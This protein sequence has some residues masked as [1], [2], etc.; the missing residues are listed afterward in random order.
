MKPQSVPPSTRKV[1]I[2]CAIRPATVVNVTPSPAIWRA[3]GIAPAPRVN[4][5]AKAKSKAK[6]SSPTYFSYGWAAGSAVVACGVACTKAGASS[7]AEGLCGLRRC[8]ARVSVVSCLTL[9]SNF[10]CAGLDPHV[11]KM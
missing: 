9:K 4:V 11:R 10:N 7:S 2:F 5:K 6:G 1:N 8:A 3:Y